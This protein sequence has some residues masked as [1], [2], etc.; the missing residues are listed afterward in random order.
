MKRSGQIKSRQEHQQKRIKIEHTVIHGVPV[1]IHRKKI[2]HIYLRISRNGD[3]VQVSAPLAVQQSY[4][5][6]CIAK[7]KEWIEKSFEKVRFRRSSAVPVIEEGAEILLWGKPYT[8]LIR[9]DTGSSSVQIDHDAVILSFRRQADSELR[10]KALVSWYRDRIAERIPDL[11]AKWE[12]IMGINV[13]EW[14]TRRM[15]TRWGSCSYKSKRIWLNL[16]LARHPVEL[17]E[18]I[19]VHEM[20]HILEPSHNARF[21]ALMGK[22]FPDWQKYRKELKQ[23]SPASWHSAAQ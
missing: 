20:V 2:K 23:L 3:E 1:A 19:V 6:A 7:R 12:P 11:A 13:N 21:Y 10:T 17:L 9:E 14:R 5:A 16:D 8:L 22:Y 4:I 15:K 18:Y